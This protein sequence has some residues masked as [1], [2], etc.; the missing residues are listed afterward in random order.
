MAAQ[1]C[2]VVALGTIGQVETLED[3]RESV[4]HVGSLVVVTLAGFPNCCQKWERQIRA[5]T[6]VSNFRS[7]MGHKWKQVWVQ[8]DWANLILSHTLCF[9]ICE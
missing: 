7:S 2:S 5:G 3:A 4:V 9:Y 8:F 1:M 6:R